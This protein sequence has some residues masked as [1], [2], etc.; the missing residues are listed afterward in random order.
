MKKKKA[1]GRGLEAI[2]SEPMP[3]LEVPSKE[4]IKGEINEEALERSL[5]EALKNPRITLWSPE[6]AA[7]LRYL[8]KTIP[9]FSISNEASKL[10]EKAIK[11]KYPEIW[12]IVKKKLKELE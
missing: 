3:T 8:R 9:E 2:I 12:D 1:L 5:Q 7:V 6:A 4:E 11:E 10:L